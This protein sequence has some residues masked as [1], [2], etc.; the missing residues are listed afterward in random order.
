MKLLIPITMMAITYFGYVS[1]GP[2]EH[3]RIGILFN[4]VNHQVVEVYRGSPAAE[5][6]LKRGDV[7]KHINASDIDGPSGVKVNLTVQRGNQILVFEIIRVPDRLIDVRHPL[8][9]E[10]K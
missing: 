10:K 1:V 9:H 3:G 5:A 4:P 6:G 8:P 7:V 2:K